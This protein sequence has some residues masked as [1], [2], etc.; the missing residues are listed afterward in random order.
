M[1][2]MRAYGLVFLL[3]LAVTSLHCKSSDSS[4]SGPG[5]G[6]GLALAKSPGLRLEV[7]AATG[8]LDKAVV[9]RILR[10]RRGAI[11]ECAQKSSGKGR[12]S[13]QFTISEQGTV[14]EAGIEL[15]GDAALLRELG[16]CLEEKL[17]A[18][19]APARNGETLVEALVEVGEP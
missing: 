19:K 6:S 7:S 16:S 10:A 18:I 2:P 12:L 8:A 17:A 14:A 3:V 13:L 1:M 15:A 9:R 5:F 11:A 4:K